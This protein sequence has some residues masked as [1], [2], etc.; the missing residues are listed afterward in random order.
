MQGRVEYRGPL[1][2]VPRHLGRVKYRGPL[3]KVPRHLGRVKYRG[4]LVSV[5][6]YVIPQRRRCEVMYL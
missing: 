6:H 1:V 5:S 2:R 3:V 4:P